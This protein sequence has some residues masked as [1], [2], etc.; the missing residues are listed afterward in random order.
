MC[1]ISVNTRKHRTSTVSLPENSVYIS[2]VSTSE[3][4]V[5]QPCQY[6]KTVSLNHY[7][8]YIKQCMSTMSTSENSVRQQCQYYKTMYVNSV[9]IRK[10]CA[11][12]KKQCIPTVSAPENGVYQRCQHQKAKCVNSVN[13]RKQS[14]TVST[15]CNITAGTSENKCTPIVS[16]ALDAHARTQKKKIKK[17]CIK[18]LL[19]SVYSW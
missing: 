10:Q 12:T 18:K 11:N 17:I 1:A 16:T 19:S 5:R 15:T 13:T 4:S 7:T 3:N 6:Q 9:N 8:V 14:A 2:T